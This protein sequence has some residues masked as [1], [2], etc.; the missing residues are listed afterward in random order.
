MR[1]VLP[2]NVIAGW[3]IPQP[4]GPQ[5]PPLI[6]I[7]RGAGLWGQMKPLIEV[8]KRYKVKVAHKGDWLEFAAAPRELVKLQEAEDGDTGGRVAFVPFGATLRVTKVKIIGRPDPDWLKEEIRR[9]V[10]KRLPPI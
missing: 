6:E 5:M 7:L 2:G 1:V 4:L 9:L 3:S 10:E 8:R